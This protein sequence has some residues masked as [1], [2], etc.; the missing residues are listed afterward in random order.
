MKRGTLGLLL[1]LFPA[2]AMAG[3]PATTK[4]ADLA[5]HLRTAELLWPHNY[6]SGELWVDQGQN[7]DEIKKVLELLL[8]K[9]TD[10]NRN[11]PILEVLSKTTSRAVIWIPALSDEQEKR[12]TRPYGEFIGDR[13]GKVT[14]FAVLKGMI[15]S[16]TEGG[17][18]D[19]ITVIGELPKNRDDHRPYLIYTAYV[20][21]SYVAIVALPTDEG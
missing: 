18:P 5:N 10:E 12:M 21:K 11:T 20:T 3:E 9:V 2:L 13:D 8:P 4:P 16:I 1:S 17:G 6:L 14:V 19:A 15:T 7:R